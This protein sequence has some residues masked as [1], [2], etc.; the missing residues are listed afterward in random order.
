MRRS[1][2]IPV[3]SA[4][5]LLS[6]A[7]AVAPVLAE[8]GPIELVSKNGAEQ[9]DFAITP[10]LSADGRY[11]AFNG[12]IGGKQG[13]FR[14]DLRTGAVRPV[15]APDAYASPPNVSE[16]AIS[17]DG[18]YVSFTTPASLVPGDDPPPPALSPL[19]RDVYVAEMASDPPTYELASALDG[20]A[21]GLTYDANQGSLA[22]GGV[23]LS[24]DGRK[25]AFVTR[26]ASNLADP[27]QV[28]TPAGQVIL[29]DLDAA[30][31]TLVSVTRNPLTG[32]MQP[33]VPVADGA[34]AKPGGT[35]GAS[36]SADGTTVAW[37]GTS[38]AAQVPVL[39]DEELATGTAYNEPLWRR[40]ADGLLAPTRR[41]VGAGDP[42]APGCPPGGTLHNPACRGPF[43]GIATGDNQIGHNSACTT[44]S[45]LG[46]VL[47]R[48]VLGSTFD[49]V[50]RLSA[51]GRTVGLLGQPNGFTNVFLADMSAGLSRLQAV[52]QLTREVPTHEGDACEAGERAGL[53]GAGDVVGTAISAAGNR[54]AVATQRQQF[55]LS[56]PNLIG[57]PP[58][59]MGLAELYLVD[60]EA[61]TLQ[62]LT[63][64]ATEN[65]PSKRTEDIGGNAAAGAASVSFDAA[66]ELIAFSSRASN[67]VAGD[68][69]GE[70][71]D[72]TV[73]GSDVFLVRDARGGSDPGVAAI[74]PPP[75]PFGPKP[76]WR[77]TARAISRPDGSV[78]LTVVVPGAG[79]LRAQA[80]APIRPGGRQRGVAAGGRNV[81]RYSV[82]AMV[83]RPAHP[84]QR[85]VR[86][87][88]GLEAQLAVRFASPGHKP[89]KRKLDIRFR[90]RDGRAG[91][92]KEARR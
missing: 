13:I 89:L 92:G 27:E 47:D 65:E 3:V 56:P 62:R 7:I 61:G 91:T 30:Q 70:S 53:A 57:S 43:P 50:P 38:L 40:V 49:F 83:L 79:R 19:D 86:S 63:H 55:P 24:A 72:L 87:A 9:A 39:G 88:G 44:G 36:L 80:K 26:A 69:N 23:A 5:A 84:F 22:A 45:V 58:A 1:L 73:A 33:G 41:I 28:D 18:G 20:S 75:P 11:V 54:V 6:S 42:L 17:A 71:S 12:L 77:L 51:D 37:L 34:A 52:R 68:G 8:P 64:G 15:F 16:P 14:K 2:L 67:L 35:D 48:S 85:L 25:V 81:R 4:L 10:A 60:L 66:G 82:V 29:R 59:G 31:T 78:R 76:R 32:A 74:S 21:A 90:D 46:W